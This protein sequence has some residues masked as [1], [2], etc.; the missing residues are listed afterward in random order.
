LVLVLALVVQRSGYGEPGEHEAED[1]QPRRT[2]PA[3]GPEAPL[4]A[5][6]EGENGTDHEDHLETGGDGVGVDDPFRLLKPVDE[7]DARCPTEHVADD[8]DGVHGRTESE[9]GAGGASEDDR[10]PCHLEDSGGG[11]ELCRDP[12]VTVGV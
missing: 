4:G 10:R 12:V 5:H 3:R 6:C 2:H 8:D 11:E 7:A 1:A 9:H